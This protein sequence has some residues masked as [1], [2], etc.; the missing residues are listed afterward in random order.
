VL[1]DK[2]VPVLYYKGSIGR[3]LASLTFKPVIDAA[4]ASHFTNTILLKYS[5]AF[6]LDV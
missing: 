1:K 2:G 3:G 4:S 5:L 6:W